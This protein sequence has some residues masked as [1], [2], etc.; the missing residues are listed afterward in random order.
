MPVVSLEQKL[1]ALKR[2]ARREWERRV[3]ERTRVAKA[4]RALPEPRALAAAIALAVVK[5][6]VVIVLPFVVL[7]RGA[8]ALYGR[9]WST[10]PALAAGAVLA[11]AVVTLYGGWLSRRLTGRARLALVA[12]WVALPLVLGWCGYTLFYVAS[13]NAKSEAVRAEYTA[14]HPLLR[15]ALATLNLAD[16]DLMITDLRRVPGD[17]PRMGLP[18]NDRTRH[19]RQADGWAHAVDLR[20]IGHGEVKNR[21][22]QVYF[23]LMGFATLRHSGTADHLHVQLPRR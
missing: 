1:S 12:R 9:G 22:V 14:T 7:V 17:Y 15:V 5:V 23:A 8:V 2:E 4:P 21:L 19:Y 18:A 10:W 20:T 13:V 16:A 6:G 3:A 11:L